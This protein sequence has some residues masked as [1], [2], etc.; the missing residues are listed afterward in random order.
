MKKNELTKA[1]REV[2]AL[3]VSQISN[4]MNDSDIITSNIADKIGDKECTTDLLGELLTFAKEE[5]AAAEKAAKDKAEREASEAAAAAEKEP[6]TGNMDPEGK[7]PKFN[8]SWKNN[9]IVR[10]SSSSK[11][12]PKDS[13]VVEIPSSVEYRPF[14][15][16]LYDTHV[17][18]GMFDK[19]NVQIIHDPRN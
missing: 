3:M 14:E 1:M 6:F 8:P 18:Q 19:R 7:H 4:G 11:I 16:S 15:K 10:V 5:S 12:G 2:I 17:K 13:D 9:V